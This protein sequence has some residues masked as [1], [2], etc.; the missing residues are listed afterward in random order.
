[1]TKPHT[2]HIVIDGEIL[3]S[4][5]LFENDNHWTVIFSALHERETI[6]IMQDST[7]K[8]KHKASD[9]T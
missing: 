9:T 8:L 3:Q 1:M 4:V 2:Q 5:T 7:A 6:T